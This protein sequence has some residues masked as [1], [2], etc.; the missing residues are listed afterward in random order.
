MAI[1]VT[2]QDSP[3][4]SQRAW[5]RLT[6]WPR[7]ANHVPLTTI[8]IMTPGPNAVGTIFVARTHLGPL[9]FDDP[10][11]LAEWSPPAGDR[12]GRCRLI[13]RGT[14]MLG[15]AELEVAPQRSGSRA[16]WTE[17]ITVARMPK[18]AD[19]VTR[20]SSRLMFS[21]VLRRLL[22]DEPHS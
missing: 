3:L 12:P 6:T 8:S 16:T 22:E 10:M 5:D 20:V 15:W 11:E 2:R 14:V 18:W 19:P 1:F 7:H 4:S 9:S 13:K 21:R 17:Q